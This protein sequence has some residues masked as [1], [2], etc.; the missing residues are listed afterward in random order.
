[1]NCRTYYLENHKYLQAY[2]AFN[3]Q[4]EIFYDISIFL[5]C[6]V[7]LRILAYLISRDHKI[8]NF[9]KPNL[10]NYGGASHEY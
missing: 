3:Y 2:I 4:H 1:M 8:E 9:L 7:R 6:F 5:P 10:W